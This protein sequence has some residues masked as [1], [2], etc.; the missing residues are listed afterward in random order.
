VAQ[1]TAPPHDATGH[2]WHHDD[3][4]LV[5]TTKHG[6]QATAPRGFV[7]GMPAFGDKL[8]DDEVWQMGIEWRVADAGG[9]A[10]A[11]VRRA[12]PSGLPVG[13]GAGGSC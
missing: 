12:L 13:D 6:G 9:A 2:T 5:E 3:A 10:L 7:S 11:G 4:Y 1:V 8:T